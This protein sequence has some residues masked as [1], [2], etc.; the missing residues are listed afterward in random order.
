MKTQAL[1]FATNDQVRSLIKSLGDGS[2]KKFSS[3]LGKVSALSVK[4]EADLLFSI[5]MFIDKKQERQEYIEM[6]RK[7]PISNP[8]PYVMNR[9]FSMV[10]KLQKEIYQK[11]GLSTKLELDINDIF[12]N[13]SEQAKYFSYRYI[14]EGGIKKRRMFGEH[15]TLSDV[16]EMVKKIEEKI[17][18]SPVAQLV[19][20]EILQKIITAADNY[21]DLTTRQWAFFYIMNANPKALKSP[22][23]A[24]FLLQKNN[25]TLLRNI[26]SQKLLKPSDFVDTFF[27]SSKH[28][29]YFYKSDL[30]DLISVT[31][32]V[33]FIFK[34]LQKSNIN[35][36]GYVS[37][38][39]A[40]KVLDCF[41][42]EGHLDKKLFEKLHVQSHQSEE[43]S[44][45]FEHKVLNKMAPQ[46]ITIPQNQ[47]RSGGSEKDHPGVV[48]KS[49]F[50]I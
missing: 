5:Y 3:T 22:E 6:I 38:E 11:Q 18:N 47:E 39:V 30:F 24:C 20:C 12:P 45:Y 43:L 25:L 37:L 16:Q 35:Y 33:S 23:I 32:G 21:C 4:N 15:R 14:L 29:E 34:Q 1:N 42:Q 9:F 19:C 7:K 50:K 44:I 13:V 27:V 41:E 2:F 26:I 48:V 46:K 17:K 10:S 36:W 49:K 8:T 31:Y 28:Q 40:K